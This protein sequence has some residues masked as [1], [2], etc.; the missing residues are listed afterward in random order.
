[1]ICA[2]KFPKKIEVAAYTQIRR[3][4][5][6]ALSKENFD[7]DGLDFLAD[8]LDSR[9]LT[10]TG[11]NRDEALR[12]AKAVRAFQET[13]NPKRFSRY[14]IAPSQKTIL[15]KIA[16]VTLK[17]TLD[18]LITQK[19]GETSNSGAI[20]LKYAFGADRRELKSQL[21]AASNLVY[22]ALEDGQM[23]PLPRLSMA[24]D[25]AEQN[26]VKASPSPQRFRQRVETSC[27]EIALWWD[28]IE[29]P[30]D[31]DGPEWH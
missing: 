2:A 14:D 25:M 10:E 6:A 22:W 16:G 30:H 20:V 17:V 8:R 26:V 7:R 28:E 11:Y 18:A 29:P 27:Q 21:A 13:F 4:L 12:C 3:Q 24:V 15:K 5:R 9:A 1:M 23:Q 31:Y 19:N